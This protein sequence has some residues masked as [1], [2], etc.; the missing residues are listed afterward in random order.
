M[1]DRNPGTADKEFNGIYLQDRIHGFFDK[2][3]YQ[4]SYGK[5]LVG[6]RLYN[7]GNMRPGRAPGQGLSPLSVSVN[8]I[9]AT[10]CQDGNQHSS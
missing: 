4:I 2:G 6:L 5:N 9:P 10:T 1:T 8:G 7:P 3:R